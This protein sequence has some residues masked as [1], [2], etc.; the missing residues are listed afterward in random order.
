M[1]NYVM[2]DWI[3][4]RGSSNTPVTQGEIGWLDMSAYQD[5]NFWVDVR[6]FS[7][8]TTPTLYFQTSP[9]KEDLLF[10]APAGAMASLTLTLTPSN[11]YRVLL[12]TASVP[13]ARY[14]RWQLIGPN[15][16]WDATFRVL[17]TANALGL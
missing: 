11:P 13:I 8:S 9:N 7:G 2:Q 12:A 15:S 5:I 17:V 14:V 4:I 3:T 6:E 16:A 10:A 1:Q